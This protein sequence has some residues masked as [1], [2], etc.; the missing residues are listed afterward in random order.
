MH[1]HVQTDTSGSIEAL[2]SALAALPQERIG[3]RYLHAA[4]GPVT[5]ADVDLA[6]AAEGSRVIAFNTPV[7]ESVLAN[8][9][10]AGEWNT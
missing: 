4:A 6:A 3:I 1:H 10:T 7:S 9:K 2:K 8:A 5:A